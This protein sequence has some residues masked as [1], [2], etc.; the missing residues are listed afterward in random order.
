MRFSVPQ[1]RTQRNGCRTQ[2]LAP[3]GGLM[4]TAFENLP[5]LENSC[6]DFTNLLWRMPFKALRLQQL[7]SF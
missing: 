6:Q 3:L 2:Q 4:W 1:V 5:M 7:I